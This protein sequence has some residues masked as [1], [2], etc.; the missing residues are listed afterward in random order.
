MD[1]YEATY[2]DDYGCEIT[3]INNDGETLSLILRGIEF[4]GSD[5]DSLSPRKDL[6]VEKLQQFP[7]H[8]NCLCSCSIKC[9]MTIPLNNHG[10]ITR[11]KLFVD[12]VLGKPQP[13]G[14]LDQEILILSFE[15]GNYRFVSSGKSGLF[16]NELNEIQ[17]QLPKGVYLL[18]CINCL[19]S[20]YSPYGQGMFGCMMCFKNLKT[21]YLTVRTKDDFWAVHDRYDR[22][23][24]ETY[25]CSE[26]QRRIVG[27]GYRG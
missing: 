10:E 18:A 7:L 12:L 4:S 3:I 25:L 5:F 6:E 19:Y 8:Q 27:I 1:S 9:W 15:Y 11:E 23:V 21:E 2:L 26:F 13:N 14:C 22:M 17:S 20:D 24:Q 16:E